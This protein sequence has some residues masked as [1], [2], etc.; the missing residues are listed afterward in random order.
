MESC[1][2]ENMA[3][4]GWSRQEDK[5]L[6]SQAEQ[7][8]NEGR[9]LKSVFEAVAEQTGRKPNSIRNYYYARLKEGDVEGTACRSAAFVPVEQEEVR[10]LLRTV[11]SERAKGVSVRSCTLGMG[12]GDTRAMLRFQNKYRSV[13]KREPELVK[14]IIA[15]LTAE[16]IPAYD[17]YAAGASSRRERLSRADALAFFT[18]LEELAAAY[19][20]MML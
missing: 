4:S 8:R 18:A 7:A 5:L 11:L 2:S 17:P 10:A 19:K 16:G 13:I 9:P 3:K 6:F 1:K 15:E 20:N 12:Q 14:E